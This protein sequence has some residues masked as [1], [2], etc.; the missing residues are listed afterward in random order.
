MAGRL[1]GEP[2]TITGGSLLVSNWETSPDG[3]WIVFNNSG[4]Q[5]DLYLIRRDGGG[6][7]KITDDPEKDRGPAWIDSDRIVFYTSRGGG[8]ELWGVR[9]D[10][11]EL[12]PWTETEGPGYWFPHVS[13]AGDRIVV[14]NAEG[15][16]ILDL[17]G[18]L[19]LARD[20]VHRLEFAAAPDEI[21]RGTRWS[22][23]GRRILGTLYAGMTKTTVAIY[24]VESERLTPFPAPSGNDSL[25]GDWLPDGRRF[26]ATADGS[27][28]VVD[29]DAGSWTE[30]PVAIGAGTA[31]LTRDGRTLQYVDSTTEAD[32]W[33][34][35]ID[36][37]AD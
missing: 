25:A 15:T 23:D 22:P 13:Q 5:E 1:A 17:G 8:Y 12:Q 29:V 27:L 28:W 37:G 16:F 7:R 31:K 19:P 36:D 18:E 24:D 34:A 33:L 2:F 30:L 9:R 3:E 14:S 6:L 21:Y 11:S 35:R 4:R 10:G 32:I 20:Q 26:L